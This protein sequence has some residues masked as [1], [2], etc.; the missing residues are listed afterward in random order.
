MRYYDLGN[1]SL[2]WKLQYTPVKVLGVSEYNNIFVRLQSF[3]IRT[4]ERIEQTW[5][6]NTRAKPLLKHTDFS[7]NM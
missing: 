3:R 5:K 4:Q 7:T 2:E 1:K 6:W